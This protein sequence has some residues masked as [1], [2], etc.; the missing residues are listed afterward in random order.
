MKIILK[1]ASEL[2]KDAGKRFACPQV[3]GRVARTS[4][5]GRFDARSGKVA[6]KRID[7]A[8]AKPAFKELPGFPAVLC[9]SGESR[10]HSRDTFA[11]RL[12][13]EGDISKD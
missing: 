1:S 8:G 2:Q 9:T 11:K 3:A 10:D 12:L 6:A 7:E 4:K 13:R 5:T